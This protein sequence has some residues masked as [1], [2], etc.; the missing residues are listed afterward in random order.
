[1]DRHEGWEPEAGG[2]HPLDKGMGLGRWLA[3]G[4]GHRRLAAILFG[5]PAEPDN[6]KFFGQDSLEGADSGLE[7]THK[8]ITYFI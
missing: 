2:S 8:T 3:V 1:M 6:G 5:Q 4:A 7:G